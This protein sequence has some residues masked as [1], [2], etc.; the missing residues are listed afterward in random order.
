M[1]VS[2][3]KVRSS[4]TMSLRR[5]ALYCRQEEPRLSRFASA[6]SGHPQPDDGPVLGGK[7]RVVDVLLLLKA[8]DLTLGQDQRVAAQLQA[9]CE[10]VA[11][12]HEGVL[13][14][15]RRDEVV[16]DV[17][18]MRVEARVRLVEEDLSL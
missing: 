1:E 14:A 6:T 7:G 13:V 10:V 4:M 8:H 16:E 2:I 18:R 17:H 15:H 3:S 9:L 12:H 11:D 5:I